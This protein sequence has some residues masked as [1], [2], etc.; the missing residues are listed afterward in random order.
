MKTAPQ[1]AFVELMKTTMTIAT[2][3]NVS[4]FMV[5]EQDV[6]EVI[7]LINFYIALG[8]TKEIKPLQN[9]NNQRVRVNEKT[10]TG[11]WF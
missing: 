6:D 8:K 1:S 2:N 4:P 9:K 5:L 10:A 7:M 3:F 11:G